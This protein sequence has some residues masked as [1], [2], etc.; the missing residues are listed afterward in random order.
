MSEPLDLGALAIEVQEG[1]SL[2]EERALF[3]MD[4]FR[5]ALGIVEEFDQH[6]IEGTELSPEYP[7]CLIAVALLAKVTGWEE[8]A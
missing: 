3:L 6:V 4:L 5:E 8:G 2:D 7:L 1:G